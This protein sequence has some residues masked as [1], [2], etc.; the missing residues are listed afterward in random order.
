MLPHTL[1]V[2]DVLITAELLGDSEQD[3]TLLQ[4][5][6]ERDMRVRT[7][8]TIPDAFLD[9]AHSGMRF[10]VLLEVDRGT[11]QQRQTRE[12][13]GRLVQFVQGEYRTLFGVSAATVAYVAP[14]SRREQ[15]I[16][17]WIEA[18]VP[19]YSDLFRLTFMKKT[20]LGLFTRPVW[21]TPDNTERTIL[22]TE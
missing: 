10:P 21:R 13:V 19:E 22:F 18:E 6:H 12:K 2:N 5:V 20:D 7:Q 14:D 9:F 16:A 8:G 1:E 11:T 4:A 17:S 15:L 3:I